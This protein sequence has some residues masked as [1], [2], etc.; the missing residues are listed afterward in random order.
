MII[1]G[2]VNSSSRIS[3][4]STTSCWACKSKEEQPYLMKAAF[5]DINCHKSDML[6]E[7]PS[8]IQGTYNP[9]KLGRPHYNNDRGC[10]IK[11]N[12]KVFSRFNMFMNILMIC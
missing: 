9:P 2:P 11:T 4:T 3:K 10:Q 1:E 7:S 6:P 5:R 8:T 12:L